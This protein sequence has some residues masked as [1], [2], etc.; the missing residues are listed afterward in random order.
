LFTSA[1]LLIP[2]TMTASSLTVITHLSFSPSWKNLNLNAV[3]L[4]DLPT[5]RSEE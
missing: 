4:L 3:L 2:L 5:V 1:A